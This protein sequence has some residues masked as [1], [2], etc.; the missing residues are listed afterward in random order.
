MLAIA[1]LENK[2]A[3]LFLSFLLIFIIGTVDYFTSAELTLS[4]FYLIPIALHALYRGTTRLYIIINSFVAAMTWALIMFHARFYSH[5]YYDIWNTCIIFAFFLITGFL[6]YFLK[7]RF[8]EIHDLNIYL[9]QANEE[10]NKFIGIAAHDLRTPISTI[11]AFS[12]L[13]LNDYSNFLNSDL[14][15]IIGFI[16]EISSSS[17]V[18]LKNL[19]DISII[20]SGQIKIKLKEQDYLDFIRKNIFLSQIIADKKEMC[21]QLQATEKEIK[22]RFDEHYLSEVINNLLSN[23]IKY[24]SKGCDIIVRVTRTEKGSILTEVID[25]GQG[26]PEEEQVK[27][28]NYFQRTSSCFQR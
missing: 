13:L 22:L 20:E 28:F 25:Q 7:N 21:I 19:L 15:R 27:L 9:A 1:K 11:H 23:A 3:V 24:S 14:S 17:L 8:K 6:L 2:L 5:I 4:I 26:I 18:M 10:K 16:K 12:D